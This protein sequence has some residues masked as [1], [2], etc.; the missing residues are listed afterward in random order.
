MESEVQV[1]VLN[2]TLTLQ[3]LWKPADL[4]M[5]LPIDNEAPVA[6]SPFD[7]RSVQ[8]DPRRLLHRPS[9]KRL[10]NPKERR[11]HAGEVAVEARPGREARVHGVD[12]DVLCRDAAAQPLR[13][14]ELEHLGRGVPLGCVTAEALVVERGQQ[15][16]GAAGGELVREAHV[17]RHNRESA[18]RAI[19]AP[20]PQRG[21]EKDG[22]QRVG[23]VV[24][25]ER[26]LVTGSA[27]PESRAENRGVENHRVEALE[28][29][30]ALREFLDRLIRGHI[31]PPDLD[32][33]D[34]MRSA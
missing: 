30:A 2:T 27:D 13:E 8:V 14:H 20:V 7:R 17:R 9:R 16:N 19:G 22:K 6:L 26:L 4:R 31:Q 23:E 24:D 32:I 1:S 18:R 5:D 3:G 21:K 11:R 29:R 25:L 34:G 12:D 33:G 10:C 15:R 28:R